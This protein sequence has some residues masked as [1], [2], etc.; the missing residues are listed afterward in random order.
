MTPELWKQVDA[1]LDAALELPPEKREQFVVE[2]CDG[3]DELREEVLSLV[4]AQSKASAF[5]ERPAMKVAAQA[6]AEDSS[7]TKH[8][9]LIGH[10]I[11]TYKIEK[12]LGLGGMGEVYL[13]RETKL[14]RRVALKFLPAQ[15]VADAERASRFEREAQALS[16]LNH[17][18]LITIYEVGVIND[19]HFIAMEFVEGHSLREM[20]SSPMKLRDVLSI[21]AQA[22]EALSAAHQSG[23][24]HRDVK[25]DNIMVRADGYVKV[26]DFGLAKLSEAAVYGTSPDAAHAIAYTQAGATMGTLGLVAGR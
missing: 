10:E 26:L 7:L 23:I 14:N 9:S 19:L 22:A 17:P 1:L 6:L 24:I 21:I 2:A 8:T 25:P 5:M 16:S 4:R 15:F 20:M 18:N 13:A 11:G 12:V 3:S